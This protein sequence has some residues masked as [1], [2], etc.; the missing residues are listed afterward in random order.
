[1]ELLKKK[2]LLSFQPDIV[3]CVNNHHHCSKPASG[4]KKQNPASVEENKNGKEKLSS[5][6]KCFYVVDCIVK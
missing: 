3:V 4:L 2:N 6:T 5:A 1:M